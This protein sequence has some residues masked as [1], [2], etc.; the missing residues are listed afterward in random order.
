[1]SPTRL[2]FYSFLA[3]V[4]LAGYVILHLLGQLLALRG[5]A[6]QR[7]F[8]RLL[9]GSMLVSAIEIGLICLPL[10]AHA[11]LGLWLVARGESGSAGALEADRAGP[12]GWER[13]LPRLS[14]LALLLFLTFHVWQFE[15]RLWLGELR[16]SDF[17]PELCASLSSTAFGGV[18]LVALGYLLGVAAAAVH[19]AQGLYH[20]CSRWG[21]GMPR[22]RERLGRA[23]L[24]GG[25]GLFALGA[26][27]VVQLA[28]GSLS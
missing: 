16:R 27:I 14:A 1:M 23:C 5:S 12:L 25:I 3:A 22:Y 11:G 21:W 18:P 28:T 7:G 15:G 9:E 8:Q 20:A 10:C 6:L 24:L 4:P 26:W 17:L 13:L 2:R 19:A